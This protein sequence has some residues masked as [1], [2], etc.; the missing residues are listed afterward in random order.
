MTFLYFY[1]YISSHSPPPRLSSNSFPF[2]P[3]PSP[4]RKGQG[5]DGFAHSMAHQVEA[6][7]SSSPCIKVGQG[8]PAWGTSSQKPAKCQG[9]VLIWLLGALQTDET[10]Q[11]P[12]TCRRPGLVPCQL[13][14]CCFRV[15]FFHTIPQWWLCWWHYVD[16]SKWA[17]GSNHFE[18]IGNTYTYQRMGKSP[19]KIQNS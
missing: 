17:R 11:L 9:Q 2:T 18:L 12:H 13:P 8:N 16:C 1:F 10:T 14:N 19:T 5:S 6:G 15:C 4:F 3:S 7:L